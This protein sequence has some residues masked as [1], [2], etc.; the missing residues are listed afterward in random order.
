MFAAAPAGAQPLVR[1]QAGT[2]LTLQ[3]AHGP[4]GLTLSGTLLDDIGA[5]L[6]ERPLSLEVS[7][8]GA[9]ERG[10][11]VAARSAADGSFRV[12]VTLPP[13]VYVVHARYDGDS[14]HDPSEATHSVDLAHADVRL[15]F[16]EPRGLR[17]DLDAPHVRVSARASSARGGADLA[18]KLEDERGVVLAHG[19]TGLDGVFEV[20]LPASALGAPGAGKL[21]ASTAADPFH[22]DSRAETAVLRWRGTQLS[23]RARGDAVHSGLLLEGE[24]R[25]RSGPLAGQPVGLFDGDAHLATLVTD[26][27]GRFHHQLVRDPSSDASSIPPRALQ[28]RFDSNA[29]WIGSSRSPLVRIAAVQSSAPSPL[30]LLAPIALCALLAWLLLRRPRQPATRAALA[31]ETGIGIHFAHGRGRGR[32]EMLGIAG[33]VRDA[34][35]AEP[36]PHASIALRTGDQP[37]AFAADAIGRFRSPELAPGS[38]QV[39]IE[40]PGY[41]ALEARINLPHRG[42][43]SDVQVQLQSLRAAAVSAYKPAALRVLPAPELWQRL[44]PRETLASAQRNGRATES[45]ARLTSQVEQAAYARTPPNADDVANIEQTAHEALARFPGPAPQPSGSSLLRAT[46]PHRR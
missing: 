26:R 14:H 17:V 38:F 41:V 33:I 44:T 36:V 31:D 25:D 21:I 29:A 16:I 19:R 15:D 37:I 9:L 18:W 20:A 34:S 7:R 8:E 46:F 45:F 22:S 6:A 32:A 4:H 3:G 28:A 5:P 39:V 1:V 12:D 24:L 2:Q 11:R 27:T 13:G 35:S 30:W 43:W 42:E 23:L 10:Q 40:A